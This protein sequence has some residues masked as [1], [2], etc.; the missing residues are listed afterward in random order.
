MSED[1]LRKLKTMLFG[2]TSQEAKENNSTGDSRQAAEIDENQLAQ[3]SARNADT[4]AKLLSQERDY[5]IFI[6]VP[7]N[8][9]SQWTR[10]QRSGNELLVEN[11]SIDLAQIGAFIFAYQNG[12]IVDCELGG[13]GWFPPGISGLDRAPGPPESDVLT[14]RD[15]QEGRLYVEITYG[16]GAESKKHYSTA[17]LNKSPGRLRVTKFGG[18]TPVRLG[19]GYK[20]NTVTGKYYSAEEFREWYGQNSQWLEP[21]QSAT[22]PN[23]YGGVPVLWAYYFETEDGHQFVAGEVLTR[24]P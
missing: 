18:Y 7:F 5:Q 4:I 8:R 14:E 20:L 10:A 12:Q 21:G 1:L 15:L 3:R 24:L 23:N 22:D 11:E 2:N 17:V 16:K 9:P 13:L 19:T 6:G